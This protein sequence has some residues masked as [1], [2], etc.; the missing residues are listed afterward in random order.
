MEI[1]INIPQ[2][3][4]KVPT[5]VREEVVQH[6]CEAFLSEGSG[7]VFHP[8]NQGCY[9]KATK[10][11]GYIPCYKR[12]VFEDEELAKKMERENITSFNGEEMKAAFRSLVKAGYHIFKNYY[13]GEW[14]GYEAS[15]KPFLNGYSEVSH[16][17]DFID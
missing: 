9:R 1:T 16:F 12:W 3:D 6:I 8:Y 11:I 13:Y 17:S 5:E 14:L 2:N 4:Y 15:K 10:V 7:R